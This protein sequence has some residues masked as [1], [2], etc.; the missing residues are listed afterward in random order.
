MEDKS[1]V[2]ENKTPESLEIDLSEEQKKDLLNRVFDAWEQANNDRERWMRDKEE[3]LRLY[4]G[5]V[6]KKDFPF[7]NCANICV[8][9]IRTI[10]DTVH[11][12]V[13]GS[14]DSNKPSSAIP[15]G[16]EDV[17]KSRKIDKVLNWQAATQF[18]YNDLVDKATQSALLLGIAPIK[19]RYIIEKEGNKKKYDGIKIDVIPAERFLIPPDAYD[20]DVE[21]MEY[22]IQEVPLTK[23]DI[24]KRINS[25][26]FKGIKEEDLEHF[27]DAANQDEREGSDLL[28]NI[29]SL[30]SGIEPS[31]GR[32]QDKKYSTLL[33]TYLNYDHNDD[34]VDEG[35]MVSVLKEQ[36][37]IVRCVKW[38]IRRPFVIVRASDILHK[39]VGES[40]PD[41]LRHLNLELN[42]IHNQRV[43]A[44]TIRN[45][46]FG[47]F[48]P[49]AGYNPN[50]IKLVPG[51][52]IPTQGNPTQAVYFPSMNTNMPEMYQEETAIWDYAERLVGAGA[53]TQGIAQTKRQSATEIATI[54]RRAGIRFLTIFNRIRRGLKKVFQLVLEYD[55][56]YL[57]PEIQV[58]ITGLDADKP[59]FEKI[60]RDDLNAQVDIVVNGNSILD[61]QAEKQEMMQAYQIGMGNPIVARNEMSIYEL[62][63]DLFTTLNVKRI[64]AYL[65]K[66]KDELPKNPEEEHNIFMQNEYVEPNI[67]ENIE[68]HLRKHA[69]LIGSENFK[70]L[71]PVG[72]RN[73]YKHYQDTVK[74]KEQIERFRLIQQ[75]LEVN[76]M[77]GQLQGVPQMGQPQEMNG[78]ADPRMVQAPGR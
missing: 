41:M 43:D 27:G 21:A 35:I 59:I 45:I 49:V 75:S 55:K 71:S 23:S 53:N 58:R 25:K 54:D 26:L 63:K 34:G 11:S 37:K 6:P 20:D 42:T 50:D 33:E 31:S 69:A 72:Q 52:M 30:Y 74:M 61:E 12:N 19:V 65:I 70:L 62:T 60:D 15:V 5:M 40:I 39:A 2:E 16:P 73:L 48:D 28:H 67:G 24:K 13:M 77:L 51:V 3:G 1:Q 36:R 46:P 7:P 10:A 22:V 32:E 44:V 47:F 78:P 68:E 14:I 17:P 57:P 4:W 18:D 56:A 38:K 66:P 9:L 76:A 64:D 29:R 8:P